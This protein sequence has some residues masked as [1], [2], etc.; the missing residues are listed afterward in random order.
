MASLPGGRRAAPCRWLACARLPIGSPGG[1]SYVVRVSRHPPTAGRESRAT[2][3]ASSRFAR[4]PNRHADVSAYG[5]WRAEE[6]QLGGQLRRAH[7]GRGLV[8]V[9]DQ[10]FE[11]AHGALAA[12]SWPGCRSALRAGEPR[13][14]S[15]SASVIAAP[16][17]A[18]AH[19]RRTGQLIFDPGER[20]RARWVPR[21]A[22]F[23]LGAPVI[24]V[25]PSSTRRRA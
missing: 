12:S 4:G 24:S 3:D 5:P 2:T 18:R 10:V 17:A 11:S 15:A 23:L 13:P 1:G 22:R 25:E 14:R 21:H 16:R 19:L 7:V 8:G 6:L 20:A 9:F